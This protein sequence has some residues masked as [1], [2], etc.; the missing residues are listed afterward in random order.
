MGLS[1]ETQ[2]KTI[3]KNHSLVVMAFLC[4]NLMFSLVLLACIKIKEMNIMLY[5]LF[6]F[7]WEI[8]TCS[9][10]NKSI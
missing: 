5:I 4:G 2:R 6:Y 3:A 1:I 8:H 10:M 7:D 9:R